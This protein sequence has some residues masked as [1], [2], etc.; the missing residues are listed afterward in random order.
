MR[1]ELV[2]RVGLP[3]EASRMPELRGAMQR[4]ASA[5]RIVP[6]W[7]RLRNTEWLRMR[8]HA[9]LPRA[10]NRIADGIPSERLRAADTGR[11][12]PRR[13]VNRVDGIRSGVRKPAQR[14]LRMAPPDR[15]AHEDRTALECTAAANARPTGLRGTPVRADPTEAATAALRVSDELSRTRHRARHLST[16]DVHRAEATAAARLTTALLVTVRLPEAVRT[17]AGA[18]T[19]PAAVVV[20]PEVAVVTLVAAGIRAV[21]AVIIDKR[22]Q[23]HFFPQPLRLT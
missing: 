18:P 7:E 13:R 10:R 20:T 14:G 8:G 3:R 16:A 6:V 22:V 12:M 1:Q 19:H 2:L 5:M 21:A 11:V 15:R 4:A 9:A 23:L 17:P